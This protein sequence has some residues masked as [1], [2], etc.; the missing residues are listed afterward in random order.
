MG[1]EGQERA[2][3]NEQGDGPLGGAGHPPEVNDQQEQGNGGQALGEGE[4]QLLGGL[5][6]RDGKACQQGG[7]QQEDMQNH[8]RGTVDPLAGN[9]ADGGGFRG[10]VQGGGS[11]LR[12]R[13][14]TVSEHSYRL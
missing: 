12:R 1:K 7:E 13:R 5:K 3:H 2:R 11:F 6:R 8:A 9:G 14:E 10:G 4:D